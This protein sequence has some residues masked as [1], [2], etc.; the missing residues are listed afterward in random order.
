M[1]DSLS[2][3]LKKNSKGNK[4][5][6]A[7]I[8]AAFAATQERRQ[9]RAQTLVDA[10]I[11]VQRLSAWDTPLLKFVD[12]NLVPLLLDTESFVDETSKAVV[13]A[14]RAHSVPLPNVPHT[15]PY[16][17]ELH[18]APKPRRASGFVRVVLYLGLLVVMVRLIVHMVAGEGMMDRLY[19]ALKAGPSGN[20]GTEHQIP[21]S[22]EHVPL[23]GKML[24]GVVSNYFPATEMWHLDFRLLTFYLSISEFVVFAIWL[25][26]S[27]R[28]RSQKVYSPTRWALPY[29]IISHMSAIGIGAPLFFLLLDTAVTGSPASF[30][31]TATHV[32]PHVAR[33]ILPT[34]VLGMLIPTLFMFAPFLDSVVRQYVL[35]GWCFFPGALSILHGLFTSL[36]LRRSSRNPPPDLRTAR[37]TSLTH[38]RSLFAFSFALSALSHALTLG[39]AL[40]SR[41][42]SLSSVFLF[43]HGDMLSPFAEN[44]NAFLVDYY[45]TL[46]SCVVWAVGCVRDLERNGLVARVNWVGVF[47]TVVVGCVVCGPAAVVSA[48]CWWRERVL[49][50]WPKSKEE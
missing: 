47:C 5:N 28:A 29:G 4:P 40:R 34:L 33:A 41:D 35:V 24:T 26:E 19:E 13:G 7:Q 20:Y 31:P 36:F 1:A 37:T 25:L 18:H 27:S 38:V 39:V 23:I 10:S 6:T 49:A 11:V 50:R 45:V 30:W 2:E 8:R 43:R 22:F 3:L 12:M 14:P 42:A 21:L 17:D 15:I 16:D 32:S 48:L 46:A 9:R 44:H